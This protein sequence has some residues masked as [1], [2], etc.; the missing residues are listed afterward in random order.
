MMDFQPACWL[1]NGHLQTIYPALFRRP[2]ALAVRRERL[3]TPDNDVL[4]I[5]YYGHVWLPLVILLHGL[6]GSARSQYIAGL[7]AALLRSGFS[8]AALNFRGCGGVCNNTA[9]CYHSGDTADLDFLYRTLRSRYPLRPLAAAGFSL[10]GNVLLKW[11]GE[12]GDNV[13]LFAAVAV[14][15]PLQLDA[16]ATYLDQGFSRIYRNLLIKDLR[17]YLAAK[18]AHLRRHQLHAEAEKIKALGD[19]SAI[20]SF[21]EYDGQVV[22]KLY[23]FK[24]AADYYRQSSSR[25]YLKSIR[26]PSLIIQA[27]DDPFLPASI[28][29]DVSELSASVALEV[30]GGGGH[31]GFIGG[32]N[33]LKPVYWLEQRIPA[34]LF[35][36]LAACS[37]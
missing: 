34:F 33:P 32:E 16:C 25:Q 13:K 9:R 5:D 35:G 2:P 28:L 24:D 11:L 21:W 26:I 7:Q 23:G 29:P 20:R 30:T 19:L 18:E 12:Q 27:E 37:E 6:T 36:Q 1:N 31:V 14:S 3:S 17:R 15:A 4:D 8:S 22:A 10:G